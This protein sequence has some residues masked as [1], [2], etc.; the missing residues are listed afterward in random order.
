M[1]YYYAAGRK[2]ELEDDDQHVAVDQEAAQRAG[3][4]K[5]VAES[6]QASGPLGVVLAQRAALGRDTLDSLRE[7]GALQPVYKRDRAVVVAMPEVR[8]EF[9]TP[10][11]RRAV[12]SVLAKIRSP[13]H[14]IM[15]KSD[16]RIV[17]RPASGSGEDALQMANEI[18]ERARPAGAS[19]RF[20]QFVPKPRLRP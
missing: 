2:I 4:A 5:Q 6:V 14:T 17:L 10:A 13:R 11:Q 20:I 8:V 9:D 16:E 1:A 15:E 19:V 3:L 12:M 18:Y 7:A